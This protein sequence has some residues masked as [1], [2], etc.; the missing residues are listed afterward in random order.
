M[1]PHVLNCTLFLFLWKLMLFHMQRAGHFCGL[2]VPWSHTKPAPQTV[3]GLR[4]SAFHRSFS[5]CPAVHL[6]I[7][8]ARRRLPGTS[9]HPPVLLRRRL[10]Q[11]LF[12]KRRRT[13]LFLFPDG[14]S[15]GVHPRD[16]HPPLRKSSGHFRPAPTAKPGSLFVLPSCTLHFGLLNRP[17]WKQ[18]EPVPPCG[19][20]APLFARLHR[21]RIPTGPVL[22]S[23][24]RREGPEENPPPGKGVFRSPMPSAGFPFRPPCREIPGSGSCHLPDSVVLPLQKK[25]LGLTSGSKMTCP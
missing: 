10:L 25:P 5:T 6:L 7:L 22:H 23:S 12:A 8:P 16:L 13:L 17:A 24:L 3:Y 9:T 11:S 2:P 20:P 4:S 18:K 15:D 1:R 19:S 14:S 21:E